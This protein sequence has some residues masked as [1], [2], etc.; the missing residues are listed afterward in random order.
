MTRSKSMN[1][2]KLLIHELFFRKNRA[3]KGDKGRPRVEQLTQY[4]ELCPAA[5][6]AEGL[7]GRTGRRGRAST[8]S[9]IVL[10]SQF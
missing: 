9:A 10:L 6:V 3:S 2:F 1:N 4:G 7:G 8:V 5:T